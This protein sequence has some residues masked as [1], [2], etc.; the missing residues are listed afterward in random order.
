VLIPLVERRFSSAPGGVIVL[1]GA[2]DIGLLQEAANIVMLAGPILVRLGALDSA[3]RRAEQVVHESERLRMM[4]DSLPDPVVITNASNDIIT[5]NARAQHLFFLDEDGS[6]GRRRAVELNNL[7]FS[8]FLSRALIGG[9]SAGGAR[10]L[11][12]VDPDEG[13]RP[14]LRGADPPVRRASRP[15]RTPCSRCC[16]T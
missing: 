11:N 16:G 15:V 9:T 5:K 2:F 3:E 14:A 6:A 8:S 1:E 10:E 13:K 12:L 7:L 4:V